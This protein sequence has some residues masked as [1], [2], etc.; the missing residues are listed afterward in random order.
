MTAT[1]PE[2]MEKEQN[3]LEGDSNTCDQ[4]YVPFISRFTYYLTSSHCTVQNQ[5]N[6]PLL[7]LPA[8]LRNRI[9]AYTFEPEIHWYRKAGFARNWYSWT[10]S[11]PEPTALLSC[12][13]VNFEAKNY[14]LKHRGVLPA[15]Q[16][17][18]MSS[19]YFSTDEKD[20]DLW[21]DR[22]NQW[23][24]MKA[25]IPKIRLVVGDERVY[26]PSNGAVGLQQTLIQRLEEL[27]QLKGL[28]RVVVGLRLTRHG[29][30]V[31]ALRTVKEGVRSEIEKVFE[32]VGHE[33]I[34][35]VME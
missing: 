15:P 5:L 24:P 32:G 25:A 11:E 20:V 30:P 2:A 17:P 6:S 21:R 7:R 23:V 8:E 1:K 18:A 16:H 31:Q 35:V 33:D 29:V 26:T 14:L 22:N 13:Q 9:Y 4:L 3:V 12:R 34:E 28:G 10:D 19:F 27:S